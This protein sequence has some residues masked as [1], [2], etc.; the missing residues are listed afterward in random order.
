MP[1]NAMI[2]NLGKLTSLGLL[3]S[4]SEETK[5]VCER[6]RDETRLRKARI[7]PINLLAALYQYKKGKGLKG[8]LKWA[9]VVSICQALDDA[10]Y[11]AFKVQ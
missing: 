8:K 11:K 9:P 6:L 4:Q 1:M 2:R 5:T 7:H 10:F 3:E